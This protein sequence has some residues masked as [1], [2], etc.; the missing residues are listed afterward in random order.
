MAELEWTEAIE[1]GFHRT[2]ASSPAEWRNAW[3]HR[4]PEADV[5][6]LYRATCARSGPVPSPWWLR[7]LAEGRLRSRAEGFR[8]EDRVHAFLSARRGWEYVPW[9][10]DGESGYWEFLPSESTVSGHRFPTTIS[11]T[12]RHPGWLDVLP[13]HHGPPPEPVMVAGVTELRASVEE[14]EALR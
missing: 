5:L 7:A 2:T 11:L 6:R 14:F 9:G 10:L 3:I 8:F 1:Q 13:A 12:D 4:A